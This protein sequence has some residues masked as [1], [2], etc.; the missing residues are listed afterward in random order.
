MKKT[1]DYAIYSKDYAKL[2]LTGT[3]YLEFRDISML[4]KAYADGKKTVLD[5]GCGAGRS[6]RFL[7]GLG[8]DVIGTDISPDMLEQAQEIDPK[9]DYQLIKSAALPFNDER[10]DVVFS[11][12][13][14]LEIGDFDEVVNVLSEM[15]RVLKKDGVILF[16]TAIVNDIKNEWVSFSYDFEENNKPLSKCTNLKLLIKDKDITLYDY[17]WTDN[18]YKKAISKAGLKLVKLHNPMGNDDDQI[19]WKDEAKVPYCYIYVI[20]K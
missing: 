17:N 20:S 15:K 16:I 9:G 2:G 19:E 1:H 11:S 8:Y 14:F 3:Y 10:F 7:K 5:Y 13:V 6:T 12:Y 4:L 18:E